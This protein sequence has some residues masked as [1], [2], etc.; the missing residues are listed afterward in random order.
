MKSDLK[1]YLYNSVDGMASPE[2]KNELHGYVDEA[3]GRFLATLDLI[4]SNEGKLLEIGANP[5]FLTLLLKK[6]RHYDISMT[7]YIGMAEQDQR[8]YINNIKYNES[9]EFAFKNVNI[10]TEL[11]PYPDEYFDVVLF[12]E[13]MEHLIENPIFALYNIHKVLKPGGTLILSTPNIFR[14]D[15]LKKFVFARKY[16]VSDPYSGYGPYGRHNHEYSLFELEDILSNTGYEIREIK[17]VFSRNANM[18]MHFLEK[19]DLGSYILIKVQ[20]TGDFNWYY[21]DY[22]F[23]SGIKSFVI[24]NYIKVGKN[25]APHI[26]GFYNLE[27]W[28][29]ARIRW[30][31]K[32]AIV[33]LKPTG[34]EKKLYLKFFSN[35]EEFKFKIEVYQKDQ[36]IISRLV[37]ARA[38]W[39]EIELDPPSVSEDNMMINIAIKKTWCPQKLGIN[40]DY[41]ELGI[42][43]SE[44]GLTP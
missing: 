37:S 20:K 18:F 9:Y 23:R 10:E 24:D 42:A 28:S 5:Y 27:N 6:F 8:Q 43:I 11:L 31:T 22:L 16:S 4:P 36:Q 32:E 7:N 13:V 25:C 35:F 14:Y 29:D 34:K 26:R 3:Y 30:T 17:T 1:D 40:E 12:C 33:T 41:R 44:I 2:L 39:Q 21:P 19:L 15:N 38:G